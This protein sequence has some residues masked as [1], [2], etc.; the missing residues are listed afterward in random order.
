MKLNIL[1]ITGKGKHHISKADI[2]ISFDS[3]IRYLK[4]RTKDK[5]ALN[6]SY[7]KEVL[8][9]LENAIQRN[10]EVS[11]E[12][13]GLF[14]DEL[15]EIYK[16]LTSPIVDESETYWALAAPIGQSIFY[17]TEPFY[18]LLQEQYC[19]VN[20]TFD[21][22]NGDDNNSER[23]Q[24][25]VLYSLILEKLYGFTLNQKHEIVRSLTDT[26]TGLL[27]YYRV[28]ID[29]QFID[30]E[31]RNQ[32]PPINYSEIKNKADGFDWMD[33]Q[34][35][36]PLE[37]F[38]FKGFSILTIDDVTISQ[39]LEDIKNLI[40][41][42]KEK[43]SIY[44]QLILSLKTM[45]GNPHVEFGIVPFLRVNDSVVFDRSTQQNSVILDLLRKSEIPSD[46]M[47]LLIDHYLKEPEILFFNTGNLPTH[48]NEKVNLLFRGLVAS[49]IKSYSLVPV[50]HNS[51]P[52]GA[53]EIYTRK[54]DLLDENLLV[55]LSDVPPL[56][57]QILRDNAVDF[58]ASID[59]I[60]KEKFTSLQPAVQWK[61]NE[62]AWEYKKNLL[63]EEPKP[64][65]ADIKFVNVY[66]LYGAIDIRNSTIE[67]NAA[68]SA[69]LKIQLNI[70]HEVLLKLG[71]YSN[72]AFLDELT[73]VCES[74]LDRVESEMLSNV[75]LLISDFLNKDVPETLKYFK[76]HDKNAEG[77][78]DIYEE[79]LKPDT[80]EAFKNRRS[81]ESSIRLINT[82]V[83]AYLEMF[84]DEIQNSYP[85]YFEKFRSDGVEYDIYIGQSIAPKKPF[86]ILY[87]K[88]IRLWQLTSMAAIGRVTHSLKEQMET[89]LQTTQLIFVNSSPIDIS[90][91]I[92][93]RR[94]DV[95]GAYNIR[96]EM[97]K[98]RI[99][100][101]RIKGTNE[102]LTQ[103]GKIALVYLSPKEIRE[104]KNSISYLQK[105]GMLLYDLEDV[106]LEELQGVHGL[107]A[108]RVGIQ[109]DA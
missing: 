104:F 93:E 86:N 91:R 67:R 39:S 38:T 100:K 89:P 9:K 79:A 13:L 94:F 98:K 66:P 19:E 17:S 45:V 83:N 103:P 21:A 102:R 62:K 12:N 48:E 77:I 6:T 5:K 25:R 82:A 41:H 80:G 105:K 59:D 33:L 84:N 87:L 57:G 42:G 95:E 73:H 52:V 70:L 28:N 22:L 4:D 35:R 34:E 37:H 51:E 40:I 60:I 109:L 26:E 32:L 31:V 30:V 18:N 108:L 61:F 99:D 24:G 92:D 97:V 2:K 29:S 23:S 54:E 27:K 64:I 58:E 85:C 55:K 7:L 81:L 16:C 36:L 14:E 15:S 20:N 43:E 65:I 11:L 3:F 88:N 72:I 76:A 44:D 75:E 74:W 90:F 49:N 71:D 53:L 106:E 107:R 78:I 46:R 47:E 50:Y 8:Q 63:P 56:L 69:D 96:Y 68:A 10:G 1:D 101:V